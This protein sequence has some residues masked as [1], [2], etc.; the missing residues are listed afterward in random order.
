M[1]KW[2]IE[3]PLIASDPSRQHRNI[4][5][6][7]SKQS[8]ERAIQLVADSPTPL[9]DQFSN[10]FF[11]VKDDPP[12]NVIVEVLKR[13]SEQMGFVQF[14]Q[15]LDGNIQGTAVPHPSKIAG[16]IH[17]RIITGRRALVSRHND[18]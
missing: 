14:A 5:A 12:A 10:H 9:F 16:N 8:T 1:I 15:G 13:Y 3:A 11:F 17:V 6:D 4:K 18:N 2:R 7:F